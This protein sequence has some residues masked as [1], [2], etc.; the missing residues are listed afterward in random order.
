MKR[1][2]PRTRKRF[3]GAK[4]PRDTKYWVAQ[5]LHE[6][7]NEQA[8]GILNHWVHLMQKKEVT[9]ETVTLLNDLADKDVL[10]AL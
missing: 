9:E 7:L 3:A 8:I 6:E 10:G 4:T 1:P 2:K 5:R